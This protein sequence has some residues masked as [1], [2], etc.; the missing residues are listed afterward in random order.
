M[1]SDRAFK[2]R[3]IVAPSDPEEAGLYG[4]TTHPGNTPAGAALASAERLLLAMAD[5]S[6]SA[7]IHILSVSEEE[8]GPNLLSGDDLRRALRRHPKELPVEVLYRPLC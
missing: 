1:S 4:T 6:G 8:R 3:W 2:V 5:E 7:A